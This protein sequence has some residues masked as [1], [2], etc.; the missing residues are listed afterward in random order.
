MKRKDEASKDRNAQ[1]GANCN[2]N[3]GFNFSV[4]VLALLAASLVGYFVFR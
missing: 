2:V 1:S 3:M 4:G